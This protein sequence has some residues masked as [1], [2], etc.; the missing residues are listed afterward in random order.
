MYF[1]L[2]AGISEPPSIRLVR[3][4]LENLVT[5]FKQRIK[6]M[7]AELVAVR[8]SLAATHWL[9]AETS[10]ASQPPSSSRALSEETTT[11]P[12][13]EYVNSSIL[14]N[15]FLR[16]FST[17]PSQTPPKGSFPLFSI[18]AQQPL[19]LN[20]L[21]PLSP[22]KSSRQ[23]PDNIPVSTAPTNR[24]PLSVYQTPSQPSITSSAL[25]SKAREILMK[26]KNKSFPEDTAPDLF[27]PQD[28]IPRTSTP[29][30]RKGTPP[31]RERLG[32]FDSPARV[33]RHRPGK[34]DILVR[35]TN[36][37]RASFRSSFAEN[38]D[39]FH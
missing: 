30:G 11:P 37:L 16:L 6:E 21:R 17:P 4:R 14:A 26:Y 24:L 31:P 1:G 20:D 39:S 8:Q 33:V 18:S 12:D 38:E 34:T 29:G 19:T 7:Q 27:T 15:V 23:P 35:Y 25:R 13:I 3:S 2:S 10:T 36:G 5:S 22:Q 9:L 28:Q 32:P